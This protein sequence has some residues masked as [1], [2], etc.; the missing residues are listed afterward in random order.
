MKYL[1]SYKLFES[2]NRVTLAIDYAFNLL[3]D[4]DKDLKNK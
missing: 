2:K 4:L 1:K 3:K